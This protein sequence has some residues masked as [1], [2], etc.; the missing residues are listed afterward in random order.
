MWGGRPSVLRPIRQDWEGVGCP[1]TVHLQVSCSHLVY[2]IWD[3]CNLRWRESS[4][5]L[6]ILS[7][8]GVYSAQKGM[9]PA[10][11][12][13]FFLNLP[14]CFLQGEALPPLRSRSFFLD[15]F[16]SPFAFFHFYFISV[17]PSSFFLR[18]F[19]CSCMT[20]TGDFCLL[21]L[22]GIPTPILHGRPTL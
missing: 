22:G 12:Q 9:G 3:P 19:P 10:R 7:M 20:S 11:F 4:L 5:S 21:T 16:F 6:V 8:G 14:S 17:S 15:S 1:A 18:H 2:W 13:M